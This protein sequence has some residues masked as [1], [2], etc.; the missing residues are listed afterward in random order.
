MFFLIL[1]GL[2]TDHFSTALPWFFLMLL[3]L[4]C[5]EIVFPIFFDLMWELKDRGWS[6][7]TVQKLKPSEENVI[8][9]MPEHPERPQLVRSRITHPVPA[10]DPVQDRD[11]PPCTFCRLWSVLLGLKWMSWNAVWVTIL[12]HSHQLIHLTVDTRHL[13][14]LDALGS[15]TLVIPE[16]LSTRKCSVTNWHRSW[17]NMC[18]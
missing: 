17:W 3:Q 10:T 8:P 14:H 5:A 16:D 2:S 18:F 13:L 4:F 6:S 1:V 9:R 12:T 7:L 11:L 15:V